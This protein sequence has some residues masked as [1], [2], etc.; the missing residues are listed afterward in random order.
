MHHRLLDK[1][2]RMKPYNGE[3]AHA[4]LPGGQGA[5]QTGGRTNRGLDKQWVGVEQPGGRTNRGQNKQGGR[6]NRGQDKQ[7]AGQYPT[8]AG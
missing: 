8:M 2:G 4:D 7:E 5:G 1:N 6:T 3:A